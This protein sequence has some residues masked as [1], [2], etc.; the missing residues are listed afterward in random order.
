[1]KA[2]W[3]VGCN[4]LL[5]SALVRVHQAQGAHLFLLASSSPWNNEAAMAV[6]LKNSVRTFSSLATRYGAWQIYW[7]AGVGT[8]SSTPE[9]MLAETRALQQLLE[10]LRTDPSLMAMSGGFALASSAGAIY[11]GTTAEVITEKS[12]TTPTTAYA[13]AKLAQ[14]EMV[15]A[16]ADKAPNFCAIISRITT[17]YGVGQASSKKLGLISNIARSMVRN[18]VIQVFVPLDTIRDYIHAEDAAAATISALHAATPQRAAQVRIVASERPTTIAEIVGTFKRLARR[19]PWMVTASTKA[20]GLYTRRVQFRTVE[21]VDPG[22]APPRSLVL[23]IAEVL[24]AERLYLA[25]T[26]ERHA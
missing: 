5:G 12:E 10:L 1:M 2:I 20:S 8:M 17:L 22:L 9:L 19:P 7:A 25:T 11:A 24:Q 3:V 26:N 21:P 13:H 23:G 14:E 15:N 4:G 16:F 18:Q 6:H